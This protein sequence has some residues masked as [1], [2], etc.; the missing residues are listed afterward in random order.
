MIDLGDEVKDVV[1]G[2]KG[3][4]IGRIEYLNGCVRYD[5]KPAGLK[6]GK[7]IEGEWVDEQQLIVIKKGA[8]ESSK[9]KS[10]EPKKQP[11]GPGR[12][13]SFRTP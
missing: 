2:L 12:V 5:V 9:P 13:P 1:T 4:A 10:K 8:F 6:Q 3:I 11:G 7:T